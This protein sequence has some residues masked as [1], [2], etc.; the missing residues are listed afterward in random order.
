[1]KVKQMLSRVY[2]NNA[3]EA[4]EFYEQLFQKKVSS[5]FMLPKPKL[6]IINIGVF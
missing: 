1:M 3:D 4:V 6:E 5:R 2:A